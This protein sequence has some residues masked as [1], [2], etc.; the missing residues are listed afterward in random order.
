MNRSNFVWDEFSWKTTVPFAQVQRSDNRLPESLNDAAIES[1]TTLVPLR[2]APEGRDDQPLDNIEIA[3]VVWTVDNLPLL[4]EALLPA[5]FSYYQSTFSYYQ[6]TCADLDG[7]DPDD[8]PAVR[9]PEDLLPL[10]GIQ[11]INVH[12]V[13]KD[14]QPYVGFEFECPWD[15]EHG[16]GVLMHGT[17]VVKLGGAGTAFLLWVAEQDSARDRDSASPH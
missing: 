2:Y 4:W 17:R 16:L 3:S 10:L 9:A 5:V 14:G 7:L 11:G 12:Q 13:S 6:S 8:L 1:A 15:E